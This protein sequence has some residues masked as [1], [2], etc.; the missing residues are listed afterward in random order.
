MAVQRSEE[1][2][3]IADVDQDRQVQFSGSSKGVRD[4][5]IIW[6]HPFAGTVRDR[7]PQILP[8]LHTP[9]SLVAS[10]PQV[11][12]ERS[13]RVVLE[14]ASPV[15]VRESGEPAGIGGV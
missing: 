11:I 14:Q 9:C 5:L 2:Q 3:R 13:F 1:G 7:E 6:E 15:Q 8:Y 10:P 4:P 12:H